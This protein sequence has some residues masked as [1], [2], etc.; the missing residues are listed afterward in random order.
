MLEDLLDSMTYNFEAKS[1]SR[2]GRRDE[3][4][5]FMV[6]TVPKGSAAASAFSALRNFAKAA[7]P[8]RKKKKKNHSSSSIKS[9]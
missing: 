6:T 4:P 3:L 2:S 9:M 5:I 7:Q 8:K 1:D